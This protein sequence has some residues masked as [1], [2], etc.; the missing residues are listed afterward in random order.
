MERPFL[1]QS[2]FKRLERSQSEA[3]FL[4]GRHNWWAEMGR[5]VRIVGEFLRGFRGLHGVGPAVT[6]FG[7][8]RFREGHPSYE[9]ARRL[10]RSLAR[11]GYAVITGG[12]PGIMEA[13]CRGAKEAGGRTL[14]CNIILPHEQRPN[15]YL[16]RV[17]T[18]SYFFVRKVMLVKYS[19]AFVIL[20]GGMGTL[21][22]LTEALTLIQTGKLYD[23]PVV[24]MGTEYWKGWL[25]WIEQTLVR[26]GAVSEGDLAFMKVTDDPDEAVTIVRQAAQGIGLALVPIASHGSAPD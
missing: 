20:P 12:G 5:L 14:G 21:D 22:E 2:R 17:V 3:R 24:L 8:A 7:S 19:Y 9:L 15:S 6:I 1:P 4:A 11:D 23:F 13:A 18:F 26:E 16:D 25:D 10:G